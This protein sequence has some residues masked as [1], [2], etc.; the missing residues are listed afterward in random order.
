MVSVTGLG[1]E[2]R[3]FESRCRS[4]GV[5]DSDGICKYLSCLSLTIC[6]CMRAFVVSIKLRH[7]G[8]L[9]LSCSLK[10]CAKTCVIFG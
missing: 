10:L 4:L 6:Y 1:S 2:G 9:A 3:G 7:C 8:H 5:M